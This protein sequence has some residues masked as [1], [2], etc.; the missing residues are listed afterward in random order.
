MIAVCG[1]PTPSIDAYLLEEQSY[2][3]SPQSDLKRR[4]LMLFV[5]KRQEQQREEEQ[6]QLR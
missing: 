6:Q 3:I 2:K 1:N 5:E 4:S